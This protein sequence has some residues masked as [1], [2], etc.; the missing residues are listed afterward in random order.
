MYIKRQKGWEKHGDFILI[1][2]LCMAVAYYIGY[3]F[4]HGLNSS[5]GVKEN[6]YIRLLVVLVFI[7]L[8][9][10]FFR[11]SY[12]SIIRRGY[13]TE[14]KKTIEHCITVEGLMLLYLFLVKQTGDFSRESILIFCV[15]QVLFTYVARCLRKHQLRVKMLNNP[16]VE[17]MLILTDHA[18]AEEC[19]K[20]LAQE[21][22]RNYQVVG[23]VL[24]DVETVNQVTLFGDREAEQETED[25]RIPE[26]E[27]AATSE[28]GEPDKQGAVGE[29][30]GIPVVAGY[31]QIY[32]YIL[33]NV[34]DSV[35][36]CA[37]MTPKESKSLTSRLMKSGVTVHINLIRLEHDL[38]NH[39]VERIGNYTVLTSSM[40]LATKRQLFIKRALDILGGLVGVC[41]TAVVTIF[42]GPIIYIQS[43][44]PIFFKQE[45]VGKN[46]RTFQI[47]KFRSMYMDAEERK[48]ELME[49][50]KMDGLMFKMDNDPRIIPIGHFIRKFSIDELPQFFN[51]LKGEMSL[52]GTRPPTVD[53]FVQ[54]SLHHRGRLSS[55]PGITG[56]WQV[57]GRS[58]ITDF[59]DVVE[60]DTTYIANWS[61]SED[62]R[63]LCK[64]VKMVILGRGAE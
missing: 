64:T 26:P 51:V 16:Y 50:N 7:D 10:M 13:V 19:V 41:I 29:I 5:G 37:D 3:V 30:A 6:S 34:V 49:Q 23:I 46:G 48:K 20:E 39:T 60:L 12:K 32:E 57:S 40:R 24:K 63:I 55:K 53:E 58:D 54:Y 21:Q 18:H 45:R 11:E 2:I 17:Q 62:I 43:P 31:F 33:N 44:G 15:L 38:P 4:R 9:V 56:L 52:V 61:I 14:L 22:Y 47:Y 25:S 27:L 42:V 35:F 36:I 8:C 28:N 1:D 59:E